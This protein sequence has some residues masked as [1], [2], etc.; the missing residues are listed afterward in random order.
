MSEIPF[1][2]DPAV[3]ERFHDLVMSRSGEDRVRM[4]CDMF[5]SARELIIAGLPP[6]IA[7]NPAERSVAL[8]TRLYGHEV[9]PAFLARIF[10]DLRTRFPLKS[11]DV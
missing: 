5:D 10:D 6:E 2:T 3:A 4:A 9:D 11:E 7:G 1:D 8:L